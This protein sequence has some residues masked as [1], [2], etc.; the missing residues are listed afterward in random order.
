METPQKKR[1]D[2]FE[3]Q[4]D[5]FSF[6]TQ[7]GFIIA[8]VQGAK[9]F[10][11]SHWAGKKIKEFPDKDGLICSPTYKL[12]QHSTLEKFFQE[13][14]VLRRF[15]KEQKSVI[16][17]P[18]GGHIWIRSAD[19]PLGIEG[20]TIYW[21]WLDEVG[22]TARLLWTVVRSRVSLTG[23]Q[24][25]GTTTAHNLGWL[26]QEVYLR[27][28]LIN[29]IVQAGNRDKDISVYTWRSIDNPYF[30]KEF[31]EAEKARLRPEEFARRYMGEFRKMEGLVYDISAGQIIAPQE[32]LI[33]KA[34]FI[35]A[36]IDWGY[37][38]PAAIPVCILLDDKWYIVGEWYEPGKTTAEIIQAAKEMQQKFHIGLFYPDPAE[39][40]RIK[41]CQDAG[42]PL[43]ETKK[44][45]KGG[46]SQIQQLI[47]EE[48][49]YV[50]N[51]CRNFIDEAENYHYPEGLEGKPFKD[52][53]VAVYNHLMDGV[54]YVINSYLGMPQKGMWTTEQQSPGI[55]PYFPELG[56]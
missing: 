7:F 23:G 11:G 6:E 33:K 30:P 21:A 53:P 20:M 54:R 31:Y 45:I 4:Y 55:R 48:K 5:A 2:F 50:F 19:Q 52:E 40:D 36:G 13:Y 22:M 43:G 18:T 42:L 39:P 16:E 29:N 9:T 25:L 12:L 14:P 34:K 41:E 38:S 32:E 51:T 35:G 10:T 49:F 3:Q 44:D 24:V 15:Y 46:I 28:Y 26:Y 47:K 8:G 1:I 56:I 37:V 17:L 27:A